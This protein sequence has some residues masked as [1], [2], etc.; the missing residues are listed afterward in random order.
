MSSAILV[1]GTDRR[2]SLGLAAAVAVEGAAL[3]G[4]G[5]LLVEM[6]EGAQRRSPTLLAATAARRIEE[7]L[8]RMGLRGAARGLVCHL[9]SAGGD[10][11]DETRAAVGTADVEL[12]VIHL[13]SRLWVP[14][15][16][17]GLEIGGCCLLASLPSERSLAAL[18]VGELER[19]GVPRRIATRAPGP[20]AARRAL[21][22]ARPGRVHSEYARGIASRLLDL[23][24]P[25]REAAP[26]PETRRGQAL[27]ALLGAGLILVLAALA[28]AAIGGAA[29][30]R[31]R[32]QRAAD[33]AA[34]SAVRSMRDDVPRLLAPARQADGSFNPRH[35]SRGAVPLPRS[36]SGGRRCEAKP[37]RSGPPSDRLPR[38]RRQSASPGSRDDRRGG[39]SRTASRW[40]PALGSPADPGGGECRRTGVGP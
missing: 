20:L 2:A 24:E 34:V 5:T 30:G 21:A 7:G 11:L 29:T 19:R 36:I 40:G 27:P 6:G 10:A 38:C 26:N 37:R 31:G 25:R 8:R 17:S 1:S 3:T 28:L 33:L 23:S 35:L 39:R 22:G 9:A 16:D 12:A 32:V 14:A 4:A 13:P 15:L 18:A